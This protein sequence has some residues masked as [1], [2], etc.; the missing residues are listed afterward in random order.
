MRRITYIC[1]VDQSFVKPLLRNATL[2][3][4]NENNCLTFRVDS[5]GDAP[6][7]IIGRKAQLFHVLELGARQC[8]CM[9]SAQSW[10][11]NFQDAS[12]RKQPVL[13]RIRKL[14]ELGIE[15]DVKNDGPSYLWSIAWEL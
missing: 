3:P 5:K 13:H 8:I 14:I 1:F 11:I 10:A 4:R 12:C 2:V 6:D 7:A 9:W 15:L